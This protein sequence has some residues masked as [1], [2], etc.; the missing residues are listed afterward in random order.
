[1][2]L[3]PCFG[4]ADECS[5]NGRLSGLIVHPSRHYPST[6]TSS[7]SHS[8]HLA[9]HSHTPLSDTPDDFQ[10][11]EHSH[12]YQP[13][14]T[15]TA[16]TRAIDHDKSTL[17]PLPHLATDSS[18]PLIAHTYHGPRADQTQFSKEAG[19][20]GRHEDVS[21]RCGTPAIS[22]RRP[23]SPQPARRS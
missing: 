9:I 13:S 22:F 21:A 1:M 8:V 7:I 5:R 14:L 20:H 18:P 2:S 3:N 17:H 10:I 4:P 16:H 23:P 12:T 15:C 6:S 19:G 11:N